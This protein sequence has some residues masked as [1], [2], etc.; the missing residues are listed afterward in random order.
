MQKP[1]YVIDTCSLTTLRRVYPRDVFSGAWLKLDDL[2]SKNILVSSEMVYH[3][4]SSQDDEVTAW[5]NEHDSIFIPLDAAVQIQ[6]KEILRSHS[7]LVDLKRRKS[8]ADPFVIALAIVMSC[9][10]VTEERPSGGPPKVKIPDVCKAKGIECITL[11]EML[12]RE[13]L[14]L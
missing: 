10:V 5:A 12:R 8:G 14:R 4:L 1:K 11:L 3:E 13:G 9:A 7:S 6:A 2:A